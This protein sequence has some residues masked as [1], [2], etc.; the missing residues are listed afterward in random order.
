LH[1]TS[2]NSF[3]PNR[4]GQALSLLVVPIYI[5][6]EK[7]E[8]ALVQQAFTISHHSLFTIHHSPFTIHHSL[9]TFHILHFTF[10]ISHH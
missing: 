5:C 2:H 8:R 6:P 7:P 10:H 9:F 1:F 3:V 4:K